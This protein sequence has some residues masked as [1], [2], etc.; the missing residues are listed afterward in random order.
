MTPALFGSLEP[1]QV[2][3]W[4]EEGRIL[5]VEKQCVPSYEGEVRKVC[6]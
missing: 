6:V 2:E 3:R 1:G 5:Q 4:V